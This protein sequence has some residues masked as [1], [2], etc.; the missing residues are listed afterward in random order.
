MRRVN[1][2]SFE[3]DSVVRRDHVW[4]YHDDIKN[5]AILAFLL[6]AYI[7]TYYPSVDS[8]ATSNT[9]CSGWMMIFFA[10]FQTAIDAYISSSP[11]LRSIF[12]LA[13]ASQWGFEQSR[14]ELVRARRRAVL[15]RVSYTPQQWNRDLF[16][17]F[18]VCWHIG[19]MWC[20]LS[21]NPSRAA[22]FLC[23]ILMSSA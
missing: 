8:Q 14:C 11:L 3:V 13:V 19:M 6:Y 12:S 5:S 17:S 18:Y 9:T 16:M 23:E 7:F 10:R 2:G 4:Q 22:R 15:C 21:I 1:T 20:L